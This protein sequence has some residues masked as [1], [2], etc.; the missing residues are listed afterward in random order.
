MKDLDYIIVGCGLAGIAFCEQL[1]K[2]KKSFVVFDN[3]S[4][5]SSSVA[6]G[7]YNPVILK[8]FTPAWMAKQQLN[9]AIPHYNKLESFLN[10][11]INYPISVH[12]KFTSVEEQNEWH[13]ASDKP[14][15]SE[16]MDTVILKNNNPAVNAPYGFGKVLHSGRVHTQKLIEAYRDCLRTNGSF[17][18]EGF[19]HQSLIVSPE[20]I[21][22]KNINSRHLVF[23][24]GF[25]AKQNP[26]FKELPLVGL[27]GEMLVIKA[28][29]LKLDFIIKSSV[30]VV[31]MGQDLYWI[32][33]TYNRDD[34]THDVSKKG[35]TQL[36]SKLKSVIN[37]EFEIVKQTAGIRPTTKDR[38]PL[39]GESPNN[40]NVF[41]LNGMGT[42]GVMIAP[43]IAEQLFNHIEF[44]EK[45]N[46]EIDLKRFKAFK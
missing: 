10:L 17:M 38:R 13:V 40:N 25:G 12:R 41:L 27:K 35:Q 11:K 34:K 4:Q 31:P 19:E 21:S 18:D 46:P 16:F 9:L 24:E 44:S 33:A 29:G 1:R 5:K 45:L 2:A 14:I 7:L 20:G 26:F 39:V 22:Y 28:P 32:G 30:F 42:R 43:F 6:A 36:L 8:R 23:S 37:C 3:D 15:L